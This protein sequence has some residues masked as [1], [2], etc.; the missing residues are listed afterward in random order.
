MLIS[1]PSIYAETLHFVNTIASSYERV[2]VI[3]EDGT[4][5]YW[6]KAAAN[7]QAAD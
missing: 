2:Y 3:K 5:Y 6:G 1:L 4:L 7:E